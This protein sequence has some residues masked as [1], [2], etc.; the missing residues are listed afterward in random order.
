MSITPGAPQAG[1]YPAPDGSSTTWWWDGARWVPPGQQPRPPV[2]TD[3]LVKLATATQILLVACAAASI[4]TI[5]V[6]TFGIGAVTGLS[7]GDQQALSLLG[8]YDQL[9]PVVTILSAVTLIATGI[10]WVLWQYRAATHLRGQTRRSPG[11]HVGSWFIPIVALWFPY[12]NVS[13]LW[14][15]VRGALPWLR[16]LWWS[17]WLAGNVL[18]QIS[19]RIYIDAQDLDQYQAAM[20]ANALG[21]AALLIAAPSAWMIVRDITRGIVRRAVVPEPPLMQ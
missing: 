7:N 15:A 2:T 12:Q 6:E 10:V 3:R 20:W 21:H 13:D 16:I 17:T 9:L 14:R 5:A 18:I 19:T 4:A 8:T 1:W 11:W